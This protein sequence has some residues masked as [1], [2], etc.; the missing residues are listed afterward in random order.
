VAVLIGTNDLETLWNS[1]SRRLFGFTI[2]QGQFLA[3]ATNR[4]IASGGS[5]R[6]AARSYII[7]KLAFFTTA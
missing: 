4:H 2:T 1:P 7:H 5:K 6:R 3:L